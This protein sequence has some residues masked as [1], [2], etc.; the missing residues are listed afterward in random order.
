MF[1]EYTF[2]SIPNFLCPYLRACAFW[3][4]WGA[5]FENARVGVKNPPEPVAPQSRLPQKLKVRT[6]HPYT[7]HS[8]TWYQ[9]NLRAWAKKPLQITILTNPLKV[10]FPGEYTSD[11]SQTFCAYTS[12]HV[13]SKMVGGPLRKCTRM[14][15]KTTS[16]HHKNPG[17]LLTMPPTRLKLTFQMSFLHEYASDHSQ[18]CCAYSSGHV[19]SKK[20]WV[21]D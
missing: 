21:L 10:N 1:R 18:L 20:V 19:L 14:G 15:Q 9:W 16:N 8:Q 7:S 12:G 5:P 2:R 4:W 17:R 6:F 11:Q 3:K 13:L